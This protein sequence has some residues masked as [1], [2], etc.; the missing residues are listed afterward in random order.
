MTNKDRTRHFVI[1]LACFLWAFV[2]I[3]TSA[4]VWNSK[5]ATFIGIVAGLNLLINGWCIYKTV[6]AV[7]DE[8]EKKDEKN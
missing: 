2:A 4:A 7:H 3:I 1:V 5:P 8:D 6:K